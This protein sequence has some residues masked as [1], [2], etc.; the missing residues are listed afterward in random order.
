MRTLGV[1]AAQA[2][3]RLALIE[4]LLLFLPAG[5]LDYWQA[6]V[7]LTVFTG[8]SII[9]TLALAK[10]DPALLERRLKGGP[11][12]EKE[13][14]QKLIMLCASVAYA[15]LL[16]VPAL[17]HRLGW[18]AS[19]PSGVVAAGDL[20][21]GIGFYCVDLVYRE[22]S[23]AAA[24]IEVSGNQTVISTGP[25]AL[26]RH[27]MYA[28]V[29]LYFVGTPLALGSCWGFAPA[30]L[31][32]G[33]LIWRLRDEERVLARDLPGYTHYQEQVRYRLL[34]FIW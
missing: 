6:W 8:A 17:D 3:A 21:V 2:L 11:M 14:A 24:T 20:L 13:R 28:G 15:A 31:L 34:P 16:V 9:M 25:Y 4:S 12:A 23:F 7:Y 29:S 32:F 22:N 33:V 1:R 30:A 18:S 26:V 10:R 27:P 19:L 5:T